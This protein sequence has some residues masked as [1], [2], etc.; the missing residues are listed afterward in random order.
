MTD[1]FN[2]VSVGYY[3]SFY[4]YFWLRITKFHNKTMLPLDRFGPGKD[5]DISKLNIED[6][7]WI[8]FLSLV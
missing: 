4:L 2:L 5:K 6:E 1:F 8:Q 7:F 3:I